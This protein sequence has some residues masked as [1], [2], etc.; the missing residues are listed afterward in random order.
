MRFLTSVLVGLVLLACRT[1]K[2]DDERVFAQGNKSNEG[3]AGVN[4]SSRPEPKPGEPLPPLIPEAGDPLEKGAFYRLCE[5][6]NQLSV[7]QALTVKALLAAAHQKT[8]A[9]AERW[10]RDS[11]NASIMIESEEL[12]E[13][14]SLAV[15]RNYPHIRN[16][17]ITV[18]KGVEPICP[19]ALPQACQFREPAFP[20]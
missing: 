18:A 2:E 15:L 6:K 4:V 13:L 9:D 7:A 14:Q 1:T 5:A 11:R 16:V 10:L 12:V 19:L 20:E 17:Y 8:C 3:I